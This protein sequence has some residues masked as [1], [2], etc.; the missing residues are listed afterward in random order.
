MSTELV[1]TMR[2]ITKPDNAEL[3]IKTLN[4]PQSISIHDINN[5]TSPV[6]LYE[7]KVSTEVRVQR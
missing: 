2:W 6:C 1:I 3:D 4:L 7:H 5:P